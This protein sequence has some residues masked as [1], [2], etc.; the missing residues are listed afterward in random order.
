MEADD[1]PAGS[2]RTAGR[3]ARTPATGRPSR[4]ERRR[5]R[6]RLHVLGLELDGAVERRRGRQ[7][8][9][10]AL[11]RDAVLDPRGRVGG[12]VRALPSASSC[13]AAGALEPAAAARTGRRTA[14]LRASRGAGGLR[15]ERRPRSRA[16][17]RSRLRHAPAPPAGARPRTA[18]ARGAAGRARFRADAPRAGAAPRT[19]RPARGRAPR[20]PA[21]P[22]SRGSTRAP[23]GSRRAPRAAARLDRG[24]RRSPG[25]RPPPVGDQRV[26]RQRRGPSARPPPGPAP[27]SARLGAAAAAA[28]HGGNRDDGHSR[29]CG[30]TLGERSVVHL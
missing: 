25:R 5:R 26:E 14:A 1:A 8:P 19:C 24:A 10:R 11:Q 7:R 27:S 4:S 16:R 29:A 3:A 28:S 23:A 6:Q 21:R 12:G 13:R 30:K 18:R 15:R 2:A 9:T 20:P 17:A 22:G